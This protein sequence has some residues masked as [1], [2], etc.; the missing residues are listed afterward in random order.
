VSGGRGRNQPPAYRGNFDFLFAHFKLM[1]EQIMSQLSGSTTIGSE[2][3]SLELRILCPNIF[4]PL[5]DQPYHLY[6]GVLVLAQVYNCEFI[7][8]TV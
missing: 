5:P 3:F 4:I 1:S 7:L 8:V 6:S 2:R